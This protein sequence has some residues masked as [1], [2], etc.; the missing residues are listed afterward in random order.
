MS[1]TPEE[2]EAE[3]NRQNELFENFLKEN[4]DIIKE[5]FAWKEEAKDS[6]D[7]RAYLYQLCS[8]QE[9]T[10]DI[11]DS[12]IFW[13]NHFG[14]IATPKNKRK[15]APFILFDY[16]KEAIVS[17]V[18]HIENGADLLIEKSREMGV[19]WLIVYVSLWYWLFRPGT[20]I[21]L[22]SYKEMLVDDKCYSDDTEVLTKDGWKLFKDIDIDKDEFATRNI[23][24]KQFEWQKAFDSVVYDYDGDFY[25]L[26][27]KSMDLM[28]SPN[29]RVLYSKHWGNNEYVERAENL[30][31]YSGVSIPA[32]SQWSGKEINEFRLSYPV[33]ENRDY[34]KGRLYNTKQREGF[35]ISGNDFARFMG[36]YLSEGSCSKGN[37]S[38]SSNEYRISISQLEKSKGYSD[39]KNLID[40][41]FHKSFYD[42]KNWTIRNKVLCEYLRQ[43]GKAGDKYIPEEIMNATKEQIEMFLYY[44]MLGDGSWK[45]S[46]PTITTVSKK[47]ADQLQELIQKVGKSSS[48][49]INIRDKDITLPSGRVIKKDNCQD[50]YTLRI[51][52]SKYQ[53][54]SVNKTTYKG[55]IYCISVPNE[56]LYVRRNGKPAWCG[57]TI[58]SMFGKLEY[59]LDG[60]PSWMVPSKYNKSKHRTKLKLVNPDMNNYIT[61]DTMNEHFGRGARKTFI[62]FDEHGF[63]DYAKG[64]WESSGDTTNCRISNS[65]PHG[66]NYYAMLARSG[67]DKLTLLWRKNPLKDAIWYEFQ[68]K[69]RTAEEIAQEIDISYS[70]SREGRVYQEWNDNNV[71]F[72]DFQYD[73]R[74]PLYV[75]WDFG[76]AD[77]T[78]IIWTQR[79]HDGRLVVLDT[80]YKTN[81]L[82]DYFAPLITGDLLT[83]Y[84]YQYDDEAFRLMEKHKTW[85][86][87]VHFGDPAGEQV[88]QASDR[89][90]IDVL[91]TYGIHINVYHDK[92]TH[93]ARKSSTKRLIMNGVDVATNSGNSWMDICMTNYSYPKVKRE[94]VEKVNGSVA[95]KHDEYSHV[96]TAFEYL[97]VGIENIKGKELKIFDKF[98]KKDVYEKR[99]Q[100]RSVRY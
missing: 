1:V 73:E 7:T 67:M 96:A 18:E 40:N 65:T 26:K 6:I 42:G 93:A 38:S 100:R 35:V 37:A 92:K 11:S 9:S 74:L 79:T 55:K 5:S 32:Y 43:Y 17:L 34:G 77:G 94:G 97:A 12:I 45:S 84:Q 39:Y 21:L 8:K 76:R 75:G 28:V 82:I 62:F 48:I 24:T 50:S 64:A 33:S 20:N 4:I 36:M 85:K 31:G 95:P 57:N 63:W 83:E 52:E 22:G 81:K 54:V 15:S 91:K 90:V 70:K 23:N 72:G 88:H 3:N 80:Y 25:N 49:S 10:A 99:G 19:T 13:I 61:G 51:R 78:A 69:R 66:N 59:A 47:M 86:K 46:M 41:I 29:H 16:Q 2:I 71:V 56:F 53:K 60:L 44:Y 27:S 30:H 89:S 68:K 14:Y 58:D 98:K 87:A